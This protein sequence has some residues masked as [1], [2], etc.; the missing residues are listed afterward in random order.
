MRRAYAIPAPTESAEQIT[1]FQWAAYAEGTH[2][3]LR[4]LYHIGNERKCSPQQGARFKAEGVRKGVPDIVLPV[5]RGGYHG[6]YIELKRSRGGRLSPE[7]GEWLDALTAQGYYAV[8]CNGAEA[9]IETIR[10][11]LAMDAR[12]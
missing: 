4:L 6:C 3:E 10:R 12:A 11:Y 9:A 5:A 2:P 1:V 7:Q 8:R